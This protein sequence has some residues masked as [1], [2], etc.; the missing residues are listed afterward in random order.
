MRLACRGVPPAGNREEA[1]ESLAAA[2]AWRR[3]SLGRSR[4][5]G[6][7]P[8]IGPSVCGPRHKRDLEAEQ[9]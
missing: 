7:E 5:G 8:W 2:A 1:G 9:T 4:G 3:R 6:D